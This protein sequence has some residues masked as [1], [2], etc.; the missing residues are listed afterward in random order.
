MQERTKNDRIEEPVAQQVGQYPECFYRV[1]VKGVVLDSSGKVLL[2]REQNGHWDLP[3]GG[4]EHGES[5]SAAL[6]RE[7]Q[8]ELGRAAKLIDLELM[9]TQSEY[10]ES[11]DAWQMRVIYSAAIDGPIV[12]SA[13]VLEIKF[14][15]PD[16]LL[17]SA[18]RYDRQIGRWAFDCASR[19]P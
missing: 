3:G 15:N 12:P 8:E 14:E 18:R 9:H 5:T 17:L 19:R 6:R 1:S 7:I 13:D 10:L 16:E 2:V 11:R 4:V